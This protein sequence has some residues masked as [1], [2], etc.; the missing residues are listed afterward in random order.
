M[1]EIAISDGRLD[2]AELKMIRKKSKIKIAYRRCR[3]P[4]TI[5]T[6]QI[7]DEYKRNLSFLFNTLNR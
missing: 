1:F 5:N 4:Q 7:I 6:K 2:G 3:K